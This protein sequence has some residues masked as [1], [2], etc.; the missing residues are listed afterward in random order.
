MLHKHGDLLLLNLLKVV[1][2]YLNQVLHLSLMIISIM[3]ILLRLMT[4]F[5]QT[6]NNSIFIFLSDMRIYNNNKNKL[7]FVRCCLIHIIKQKVFF[8]SFVYIN[9]AFFFCS[10]SYTYVCSICLFLNQ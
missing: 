4:N 2:C 6:N 3:N 9:L 7:R 8:L 10:L 1:Q 5:I